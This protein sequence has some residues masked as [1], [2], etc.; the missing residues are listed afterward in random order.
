MLTRSCL[1]VFALVLQGCALQVRLP[2]P[3]PIAQTC[4]LT[5]T[6]TRPEPTYIYAR[7]RA[8]VRLELLPPIAESLKRTVCSKPSAIPL[9]PGTTLVVTDFECQITGIVP[10]NVVVDLR[11]RLEVP[12]HA[13]IELRAAEKAS[14]NW[15]T[16][17]AACQGP[18]DR[19]PQAMTDRIREATR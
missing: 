8:T 19:I 7:E 5:V 16:L 13:Q 17:M 11:A 3:E 14:G 12:S 4:H 18:L 2:A 9:S 10:M 6:D 15:S 1:L